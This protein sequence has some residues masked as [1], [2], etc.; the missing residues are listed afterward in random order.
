MR[1]LLLLRL[2]LLLLPPP[3][4]DD[5]GSRSRFELI[6]SACVYA[7]VMRLKS[8]GSPEL[9]SGWCFFAVNAE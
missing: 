6:S 7:D 2:L 1:R 9:T 5:A 8:S 4:L 3:V